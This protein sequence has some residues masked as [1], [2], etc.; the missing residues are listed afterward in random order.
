[1]GIVGRSFG[2]LGIRG[3]SMPDNTDN[4]DRVHLPD[5]AD[6]WHEYPVRATH[7]QRR[8]LT[9]NRG[10]MSSAPTNLPHESTTARPNRY[11]RAAR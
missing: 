3:R 11:G 2:R 10:M 5:I 9:P 7:S 1:M 8:N 4:S 6:N